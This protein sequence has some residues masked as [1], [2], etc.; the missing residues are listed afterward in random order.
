MPPQ[1]PPS[2]LHQLHGHREFFFL[3]HNHGSSFQTNNAT[4]THHRGR[5][6]AGSR[7]AAVIAISMSVPSAETLILE[8]KNAL[9]RVRLLLDSQTGQLV[10]TGQLV[11]VSSQLWL[12]LQKWLNK[13]GRIGNWT[14]IKLLI[15]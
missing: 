10:N 8:R 3:A 6:C 11:K 4:A 2:S 12:K 7:G 5:V 9:P 13:R 1:L 14:G 15:N